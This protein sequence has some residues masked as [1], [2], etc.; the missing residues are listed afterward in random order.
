MSFPFLADLIKFCAT[1]IEMQAG[2]VIIML[3]SRE[4]TVFGFDQQW[5]TPAFSWT[6]PE[7]PPL[8]T[9]AQSRR[10]PASCRVGSPD[11]FSP[12]GRA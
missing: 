9:H 4:L 7:Q 1:G 6:P 2:N 8:P 12:A 11:A 5:K 3:K 10:K